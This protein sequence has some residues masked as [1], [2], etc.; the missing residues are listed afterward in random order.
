MSNSTSLFVAPFT[1]ILRRDDLILLQN[2][3]NTGL[4]ALSRHEWEA[5]SKLPRQASVVYCENELIASLGNKFAKKLV[6]RMS[7]AGFMLDPARLVGRFSSK[8]QEGEQK[9]IQISGFPTKDRPLGLQRALNSYSASFRQWGHRPTLKIVDFSERAHN[10]EANRSSATVAAKTFDLEVRYIDK[11]CISSLA[12]AISNAAGVDTRIVR[13]VLGLD[14][15]ATSSACYREFSTYGATRNALLL[16][17]PNQLLMTADDDT[18]CGSWP[19]YQ[20][21]CAIYASPDEEPFVWGRIEEVGQCERGL[22]DCLSSHQLLLGK[23]LPDILNQSATHSCYPPVLLNN[24]NSRVSRT[25]LGVKGASGLRSPLTSLLYRLK[26]QSLTRPVS[27]YYRNATRTRNL[28]RWISHPT[29]CRSGFCM[30][31]NMALDNRV[32][33][34]PF[35]PFQRNEDGIFGLLCGVMPDACIAGFSPG[36][37]HH[38]PL[39]Q[40]SLSNREMWKQALEWRTPD[41]VLQLLF[42]VVKSW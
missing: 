5:L 21:T 37:I 17:C 6:S 24:L 2:Q 10:C 13:F 1:V 42:F 39:E 35:F 27:G 30:G 14:A 22:Y 28:D 34:P 12:S 23:R 26:R 33:L 36:M 31:I 8:G 19:T 7:E 16:T 4:L 3:F 38:S 29:V 41:Y 18:Y 15:S 20:P 11:T 32:G 25:F 40:R 9:K